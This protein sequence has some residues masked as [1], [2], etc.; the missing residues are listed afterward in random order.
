MG[1]SINS[2]TRR[3]FLAGAA[4]SVAVPTAATAPSRSPIPPMRPGTPLAAPALAPRGSL[5]SVIASANLSGETAVVA[6][7]AETGAEVES[8]G[9]ERAMPPASVAKAIT[10]MYAYQ[11]LGPEHGFLTRIESPGTLAEG[12]LGGDL[13]LRGSGDPTL[14]TADLARLAD[15]LVARGLRRISG[16]FVVDESSLARIDQIDDGQPAAAGYNPAVSGL[17]LNFNRVHFGWEARNG[18]MALALDAR[19]EREVPPVSVIRIAAAARDLPV[20][21]HDLQ[22][23]AEAWTVA[24]SALRQPG[25][26]WLPVRRP[27]A[28]AGDVFRALMAARGV[29]LPEPQVTRADP[30]AVLAEHRSGAMTGILREMLRHSTNITA[31]AVG[32]TASARLGRRAEALAPSADRMNAWIGERYGAAGMALVDHSGLG[33]DSRVAPL[34]MARYLLAARREGVLPGLLRDFI[35][36][37]AQGRENPAHPV[38]V[39]AK[40]GT[41]NFVSTL[42]GYAQ[43]RGGRPVVFA[44]FS[45]DLDRRRRISEA[46][47]ER[48]AGTRPWAGAA[49]GLQQALIERWAQGAS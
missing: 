33:P 14:Q 27:G 7:D 31:E 48:P 10:A 32:L 17:N 13:I 15:A 2:L 29:T 19:S 9:A 12:V 37:D 3:V 36:R 46:E 21:T 44:I 4:A 34:V 49:R 25:S 16:R 28:Y 39:L 42:A 30:A 24:A 23:G 26:R 20:Y 11:V 43:M 41:L 5:A 8:A 45:A 40:T 6:L 47:G 38:S 22:G 1:Y 18:Q 35:L